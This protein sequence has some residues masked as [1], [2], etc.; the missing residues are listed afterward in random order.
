MTAAFVVTL[1]L[2]D[3]AVA[4]M[5]GEATDIQDALETH[6]FMV[7]SVNPWDRPSQ[8]PLGTPLDAGIVLPQTNT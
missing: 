6:G 3:G 5:A 7:V 1:D 8:N 4:D 2:S